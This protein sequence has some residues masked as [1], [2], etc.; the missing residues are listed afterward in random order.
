MGAGAGGAV[1]KRWALRLAVALAA[2]Y[3][4]VVGAAF[5]FQRELLFERALPGRVPGAAL[6]LDPTAPVTLAWVRAAPGMPTVLHCH[7][8]GEQLADLEPLAQ[9]FTA[10]GLSFAAVEHPGVGLGPG[11]PGEPALLAAAQAAAEHLRRHGVEGT[12]LVLS[13]QS[14]GSGVAVALA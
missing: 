3:A 6:P 5:V 8:N 11:E 10:R 1:L 9:L 4:S 13:G 14:L 7:G 12:Q 2:L